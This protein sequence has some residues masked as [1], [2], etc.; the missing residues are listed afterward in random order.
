MF[1]VHIDAYQNIFQFD[2]EAGSKV[3]TPFIYI[4]RIFKLK[5]VFHRF[6]KLCSFLIHTIS[7]TDHGIA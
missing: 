5:Q 4:K 6:C 3:H 1:K 2:Y 7:G